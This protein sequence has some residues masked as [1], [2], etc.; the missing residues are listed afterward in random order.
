VIETS[1][2]GGLRFRDMSQPET[3]LDY[4]ELPGQQTIVQKP[5]DLGFNQMSLNLEGVPAA[6]GTYTL[7]LSVWARHSG[8]LFAAQ[9]LHGVPA[10]RLR[11]NVAF[12]ANPQGGATVHYFGYPK[13]GGEK[14]V[15]HPERTFG[16]CA[17]TLYTVS[18]RVLRLSAQF[19][20]LGEATLP[21]QP[22]AHGRRP[23]GSA[24][25]QR[26]GVSADRR[27]DADGASGLLRVVRGA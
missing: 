4:P 8:D 3:R 14:L 2:E 24:A 20:S 18:D 25:G 12:A 19:M 10:A 11:G 22:A 26:G 7:R 13:A 27:A 6:D 9:E 21:G 15:Y 16:P 23:G 1:G 17:G 5:I